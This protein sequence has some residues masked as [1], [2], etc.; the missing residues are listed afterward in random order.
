[1]KITPNN[2]QFAAYTRL[3]LFTDFQRHIKNGTEFGGK[4]TDIGFS[5]FKDILKKEEVVN[6][7]KIRDMSKS[8]EDAFQT[9]MNYGKNQNQT[10]KIREVMDKAYHLGL[11]DN[12][13]TLIDNLDKKV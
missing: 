11:V 2:T 6:E 13:G 7:K 5:E 8:H 9:Q 10:K 3:T 4:S 12:D 1:M